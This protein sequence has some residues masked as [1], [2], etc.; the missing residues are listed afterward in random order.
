VLAGRDLIGELRLAIKIT[1]GG[2]TAWWLASELGARRPIFAA[3]VPL[4]AMTGDPFAAVSVSIARIL[5]VFAGVGIGIALT[6]VHV[7]STEKVAIALPADLT[8]A[9]VRK[10]EAGTVRG[11]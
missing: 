9:G 3:L 1:I 7:S 5:G 10:A 2:T 6:H 4:V 11:E 8:P